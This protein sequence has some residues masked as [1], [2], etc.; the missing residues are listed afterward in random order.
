M[1]SK[2]RLESC[3]YRTSV[4]AIILNDQSH[5]LLVKVPGRGWDLP[6]GGLEWDESPTAA[7]SRELEE[8]LGRRGDIDPRPALVVPWTN[9]AT[10]Y[11]LLTI[12]Y[13]VQLDRLSLAPP[14]RHEVR[15]FTLAEYIEILNAP[16]E[17]NWQTSVDYQQAVRSMMT[18]SL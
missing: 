2:N 17:A 4:K 11:H 8:E 7:L 12:L 5:I 1:K 14:D 3:T 10:G 18:K 13:Y 16:E 15:Y 9:V 6:G